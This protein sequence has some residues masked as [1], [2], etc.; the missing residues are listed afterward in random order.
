MVG[1][2]TRRNF[3]QYSQLFLAWAKAAFLRDDPPTCDI[4]LRQNM[5]LKCL[6]HLLGLG[7]PATDGK[8]VAVSLRHAIMRLCGQGPTPR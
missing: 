1:A 4:Y 8:K 7:R 6:D 2:L 5:I 3:G